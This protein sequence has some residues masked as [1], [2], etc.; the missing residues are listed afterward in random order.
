[1]NEQLGWRA[2]E[3]WSQQKL[4]TGCLMCAD[5]HADE[6]PFSFK[7]ADLPA[8]IARLSRNQFMPG[9]TVVILRRHACE[10]FELDP[11]DLTSLFSDVAAIARALQQVYA[12]VKINYAVFGNLTPHIHCHVVPR[13]EHEDPSKPLNMG[14]QEVFLTAAEY[15]DRLE[16][17]RTALTRT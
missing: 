15:A 14:E 10:L 11:T 6:N 2:A 5:A 16:A 8:S 4:G 17:L 12:P 7:I 13:F 1:M 3:A 9:W